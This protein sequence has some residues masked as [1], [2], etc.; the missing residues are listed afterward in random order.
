MPRP[1]VHYSSLSFYICKVIGSFCFSPPAWHKLCLC[2]TRL[3]AAKLTYNK[4]EFCHSIFAKSLA[5]FAFR[6]P[7]G[8]NFVYAARDQWLQNSP[9]TKRSFVILTTE[10]RKNLQTNIKE[11]PTSRIINTER[12]SSHTFRMTKLRFVI[13]EFCS[14]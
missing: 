13:G 4:T 14:H 5:R 3:M 2:C 10:R 6:H 8:I 12:D 11:I 7:R 9:I 1:S